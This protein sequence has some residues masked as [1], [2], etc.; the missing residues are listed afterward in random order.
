MLCIAIKSS[1]RYGANIIIDDE[2]F[3]FLSA[4][5]LLE[6]LFDNYNKY[7]CNGEF[8]G[9]VLDTKML[10]N[11]FMVYKGW[12]MKFNIAPKTNKYLKKCYDDI[13]FC[14]HDEDSKITVNVEAED[15]ITSMTN[16]HNWL[17][18]DMDKKIISHNLYLTWIKDEYIEDYENTWGTAPSF[19]VLNASANDF[20]FY[21]INIIKEFITKNL[22]AYFVD[23]KEDIVYHLKK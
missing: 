3:D 1:G 15:V 21:E 14:E 8:D 12:D 16:C 18:I 22:L 7:L 5:C 23:E 10:V 19:N 17:V 11:G 2:K 6:K 4:L 20:P 9:E 13:Y